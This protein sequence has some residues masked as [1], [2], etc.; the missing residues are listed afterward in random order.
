MDGNKQHMFAPAHLLAM[1]HVSATSTRT[2]STSTT[3]TAIATTL[4]VW[5][6]LVSI[7]NKSLILEDLFPPLLTLRWTGLLSFDKLRTTMSEVEG[8][9]SWAFGKIFYFCRGLFLLI[10]ISF[11]V[12]ELQNK[13]ELWQNFHTSQYQSF[14]RSVAWLFPPLHK[15]PN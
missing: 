7:Q 5:V 6:R 13:I 10:K 8:L 14:V 11:P 4:S 9:N 3:G 12:V 15:I 2:A 1:S